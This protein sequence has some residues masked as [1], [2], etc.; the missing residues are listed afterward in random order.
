MGNDE[1]FRRTRFVPSRTVVRIGYD[2]CFFEYYGRTREVFCSCTGGSIRRLWVWQGAR[3]EK[4]YS[5]LGG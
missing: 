3:G 4:D 1:Y 5:L 2:R